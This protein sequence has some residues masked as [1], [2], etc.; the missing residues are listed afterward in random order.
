MDMNK[1]AL[2]GAFTLWKNQS[3]CV[4][5]YAI[6]FDTCYTLRKK[7]SPF[8]S[9]LGIQYWKKLFPAERIR[10]MP[11]QRNFQ[12]LCYIIPRVHL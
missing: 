12:A 3:I 10:G 6:F 4:R 11:S 2:V 1:I 9:A 7:S 5:I 8:Q